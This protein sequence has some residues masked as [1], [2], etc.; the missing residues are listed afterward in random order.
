[1]LD[2]FS[3][4]APNAEWTIT[5]LKLQNV[6]SVKLD[7]MTITD[8]TVTDESITFMAPD[9]EM[10]EH[11]L[12]IFDKDGVAVSFLT[13]EGLVTEVTVVATTEV[14]IWTGPNY[15]QWNENR[16]RIESADMAQV[17]AGSTILIYYEKLP[18]GHE[19]YYENGEY[20]E[21][22]K[23]KVMTAWWSDLFPEFDVNEATPNPYTFVYTAAMKGL[24]DEQ[25]ALSGAGWG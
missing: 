4:F 21:Y 1:M 22:Q 3:T 18:A 8:I 6:T 20:K 10:G 5:G 17:P 14:V 25:N 23:M 19:G 15:I 13:D 12:A 9:V 11:K 2:G 16:V 7:Q 24:V